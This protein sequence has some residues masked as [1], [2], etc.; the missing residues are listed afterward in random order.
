MYPIHLA[1]LN[2]SIRAFYYFLA[3]NLLCLI[4]R[5]QLL[6]RVALIESVNSNGAFNSSY[7]VFQNDNNLVIRIFMVFKYP[8][9]G[10]IVFYYYI[11]N[12][13]NVK[14]KEHVYS[15]LYEN[16]G[17]SITFSDIDFCKAPLC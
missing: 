9:L 6:L 8:N 13:D 17:V 7:C 5:I 1:L 14:M 12:I 10:L 11:I 15:I 4:I 2:R 3:M 16:T